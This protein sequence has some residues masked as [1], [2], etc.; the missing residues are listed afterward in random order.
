MLSKIFSPENAPHKE[1]EHYMTIELGGKTFDIYYGYYSTCDRQNPQ[2]TPMPIY[3]DF[4]KEPQ[5]TEKGAPFA[6][7]MQDVCEHYDG[8]DDVD[9]D[10]SQCRYFQSG[11]ELLGVCN[12]PQRRRER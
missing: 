11:E 5:Y 1:G 9:A 6:T 4:L 8:M 7:M 2:V 12:C 3:P 10:C